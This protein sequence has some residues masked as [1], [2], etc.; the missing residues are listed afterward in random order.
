MQLEE[1]TSKQY[2]KEEEKQD[3]RKKKQNM[4]HDRALDIV[5]DFEDLNQYSRSMFYHHNEV[6]GYFYNWLL[7][8]E[9]IDNRFHQVE[10]GILWHPI[11]FK[12]II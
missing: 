10:F 7:F 3:D 11:Y 2:L 1:V 8:L 5:V 9:E 12:A 4:Q 6:Q